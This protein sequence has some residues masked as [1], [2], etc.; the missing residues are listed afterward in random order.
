MASYPTGSSAPPP[1]YLTEK[2]PMEAYMTSQPVS[3]QP[4]TVQPGAMPMGQPMV[5][6]QPMAMG[7]QM[8]PVMVLPVNHN[9]TPLST[10]FR[11]RENPAKVICQYCNV[12]TITKTT[13][14]NGLGTHLIAGGICLVGCWLGCCFIPYCIDSAKDTEHICGNCNKVVGKH[15]M[16][17]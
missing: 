1:A 3:A 14:L 10:T 8:A 9:V 12:E 6:A 2:P 17:S 15:Q 4:G 16:M 11:F 5:V 7:Q 13:K